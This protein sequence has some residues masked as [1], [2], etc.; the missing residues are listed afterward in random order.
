MSQI[1]ILRTVNCQVLSENERCKPCYEKV[2]QNHK[3]TKITAGKSK[4][5]LKLNAPLTL[6]SHERIKNTLQSYRI[7]NKQLSEENEKLQKLIE[8]S[9]VKTT[10][11][12]DQDLKCIISN[13]DPAKISP[14]M[15][16]F[17]GEQQKYLQSSSTGVRYHPAIIRYCLSLAAKS[18]SMYV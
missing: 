17:W 18:S 4:E 9:A 8:K 13:A 1:E 6:V 5:P 2:Y 14:F 10:T 7:E 16:F 11:S 15:K 3:Q 12:L